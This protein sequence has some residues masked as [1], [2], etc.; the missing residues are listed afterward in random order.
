MHRVPSFFALFAI[1]SAVG[2]SPV[3]DVEFDWTIDGDE[4]STVCEVLPAGAE[5]AF[6][7]ASRASADPR[8]GGVIE[9]LAT[10]QCGDG[11]ASIQ[12]GAFADVLVRVVDGD[13]VLGA[14]PSVVVAPGSASRG[15]VSDNER[16]AADITLLQGSMTATLTV[17]GRTCEEA[18]ATSF[19]VSLFENPEPNALVAV[20]GAVDVVVPCEGGTATFTHSPVRVGTSYR[21]QAETSIGD[22]AFA[23]ASAG[24]GLVARG[25]GTVVTVDLQAR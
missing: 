15:Y 4:P 16:A 14:A 2:C 12:T 10:A 11:T 8:D 6:T 21:V 3:F 22:V 1:A 25:A 23:T 19:T 18:G 7:I 24:E 9:T 13:V 17:G 20:D 5:I